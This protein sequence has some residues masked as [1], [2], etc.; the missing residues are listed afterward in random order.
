MPLESK[1]PYIYETDEN[2]RINH[3]PGNFAT[4]SNEDLNHLER[5]YKLPAA[6]AGNIYSRDV[7]VV[8]G[9]I[10]ENPKFVTER[11]GDLELAEL[12]TETGWSDTVIDQDTAI[13]KLLEGDRP[14]NLASVRP[15]KGALGEPRPYGEIPGSIR[16]AELQPTED[17]QTA[18]G[19]GITTGFNNE[20]IKNEMA[21]SKKARESITIGKWLKGKLGLD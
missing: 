4:P 3:A 19:I 12:N 13:E 17:E 11:A 18:S 20:G 2:S 10:V 14:K 7:K 16:N 15:T 21:K 9:P 8:T 5:E 1:R 6:N